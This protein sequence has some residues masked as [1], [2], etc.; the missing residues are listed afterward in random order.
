MS[1]IARC[2]VL[3]CLPGVAGLGCSSAPPTPCRNCDAGPADLAVDRARDRPAS[4]AGPAPETASEVAP[5]ANDASEER[6]P[7]T[8]DT[9]PGEAP[10]L[11]PIPDAGYLFDD[12]FHTGKASGWELRAPD[13]TD[14]SIGA[15]SVVNGTSGN[16]LAQGIVDPDTWQIAYTRAA[17]T[18]P[19]QIIEARLR[20]VELYAAT[21]SS[22][23]AL[24]GRYDPASDSGYFV[25]LRGDGAALIRKRDHGVS[26]S[27]GGAT[28]AAIQSGIW[29]TVRLEIMGSAI[30]A[31]IDG[32]PVYSV[33]DDAPLYGVRVALGTI[34]ATMEVD[35]VSAGEP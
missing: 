24:F 16:V 29:Y 18:G 5:P 9:P 14:A 26:A 8:R 21:P 7:A 27:W 32:L 25:A 28:P 15:W 30:S 2:C 31:F 1:S 6:P 12:D 23:V 11:S 20:I 33:I 19:D 13:G 17:V 22:V 34:G 4:E 10:Q 35:R 3:I